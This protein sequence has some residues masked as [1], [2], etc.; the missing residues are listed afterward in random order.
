MELTIVNKPN[1]SGEYRREMT[2]E[3]AMDIN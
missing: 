3:K 1:S 2:G